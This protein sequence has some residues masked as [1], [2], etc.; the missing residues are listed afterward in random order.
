ML[1]P[2]L[3]EHLSCIPVWSWMGP[4]LLVSTLHLSCTWLSCS[5]RQKVLCEP[6]P[7][8]QLNP[9]VGNSAAGGVGEWKEERDSVTLKVEGL[10]P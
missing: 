1:P 8:S 10:C 4:V 6:Q 5:Q 7:N 2:C 9:Y 3:E